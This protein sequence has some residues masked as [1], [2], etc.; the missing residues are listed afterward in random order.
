MTAPRFWLS[1][2]MVS[3]WAAHL[4]IVTWM[5]PD[6][7][8]A[9]A[10]DNS[11]PAGRWAQLALVLLALSAVIDGL[12]NDALPE[13]F[14]LLTKR[15]RHVGFM[16]MSIVLVMLAFAIVAGGAAQRPVITSYLLCALFAAWVA[17][18]D[19][20]ARHTTRRPKT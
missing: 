8:S 15:Y 13:R 17:C 2:L 4:P 18:L 6:S 9:R 14:Q 5:A 19:L 7:L 16:A 11:G 1:R 3:A 12:V 20:R 10:L